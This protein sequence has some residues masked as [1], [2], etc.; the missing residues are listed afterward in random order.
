MSW[1]ITIGVR[2]KNWCTHPV[3][4]RA[5]VVSSVLKVWIWIGTQPLSALMQGHSCL[6]MHLSSCLKWLSSGDFSW[7]IS[8]YGAED[9]AIVMATTLHSGGDSASQA[10][11]QMGRVRW[12]GGAGRTVAK[13]ARGWVFQSPG[14]VWSEEEKGQRR[15]NFQIINWS[16]AKTVDECHRTLKMQ[17]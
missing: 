14:R 2:R 11:G 16:V 3:L 12:R 5:K 4:Q 13:G 9:A 8:K 1:L 17:F 7:N 6:Q 10:D 15:W